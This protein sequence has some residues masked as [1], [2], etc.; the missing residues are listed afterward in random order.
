MAE[1]GQ[2]N[3]MVLSDTHLLGTIRGHW[4]DK[5]RREWQMYRS[6]QTA[7]TLFKPNVVFILGDIFDEGQW[8]SDKDY[9]NYVRRFESLF[10]VPE[11]TKR[12]V[13]V[14]NHDVGFHYW[15]LDSINAR[16]ERSMNVS[17]VDRLDFAEG[18]SF[19]RLNSMAMEGDGCNLCAEAETKIEQLGRHYEAIRN[20]TQ[21][22]IYPIL[23]TH[24]PLYRP[25]EE[26]CNEI[27]SAPPE[28]KSIQH[29]TRIDTMSPE[30]SDYLLRTLKPRL[31]LNGHIHH[32][33]VVRHTRPSVAEEW[34]V[35]SFSWR[36]RALPSFLLLQLDA[37]HH[38]IGKCFLPNENTV[39]VT[40][41]LTLL[42]IFL[43]TIVF[44]ILLKLKPKSD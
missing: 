28:E 33:C 36:N 3:A 35:A 18:I 4:F 6:F 19:V 20:Q 43:L 21:K 9:Y 41:E 15:I 22:P 44:H 34:T 29:R 32:S 1:K 24:F 23:L 40:Y 30:A 2:L 38:E 25:N 14:G 5:L 37:Q 42:F 8:A 16:F 13:V 31:V 26:A 17:S 10:A 12:Y 7:I 11:D 27:D 39:I